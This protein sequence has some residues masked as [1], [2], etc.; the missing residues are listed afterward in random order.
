MKKIFLCVYKKG[1]VI[2]M[3]AAVLFFYRESIFNLCYKIES[4]ISADYKKNRELIRPYF[5]ET[6]YLKHYAD[7]VK[8]SGLTAIDHY[9][10]RGWRGK[11]QT[12]TDPNAWFNTTLYKERLWYKSTKFYELDINPFVDFIKQPKNTHDTMAEVI[13]IY[14]KQDELQRAWLAAEGFLRKHKYSV[15]VHIPSNINPKDLLRFAPQIKR[16]LTLK[17]DNDTHKSFYQSPFL[18]TFY[19]SSLPTLKEPDRNQMVSHV[20]SDNKHYLWH[21]LYNPL[22]WRINGRLDPCMINIGHYADEPI[23]YSRYGTTIDDFSNY[24]KRIAEGFDF[25]LLNTQIDAPNAIIIPGYLYAWVNEEEL[26][27]DKTYDVSFLLSMGGGSW[28]SFRD[29]KNLNYS[30]RKSIWDSAA[31]LAIAT[32]FYLSYRDKHKFPKDMQNSALPTDSKKWIF[33]SQF[34]IAVENTAQEHYF[35]EKLLGCFISL[36]IPIYI[37]CPNIGDYFDTRGMFIANSVED[38]KKIC[39]SITPETYQQMLPYL[40]ENKRRAEEFLKLETKV[41]DTFFQKMN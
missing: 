14:A 41:L 24:M 34:N 12:H 21:Q 37:G 8:A 7:R 22:K 20:Q 3:F 33:N 18:K 5:D 16:G 30:L 13:T 4:S 27:K 26:S 1:I 23:V 19:T 40:K 17:H 32:Q 15:N 6:F 11:W 31:D 25:L 39:A 35:T 9:L 29:R 28:S 38:V 2:L 36:T 10:Q